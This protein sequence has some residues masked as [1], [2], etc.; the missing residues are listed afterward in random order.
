MRATATLRD[1]DPFFFVQH[2]SRLETGLTFI[3]RSKYVKSS[4]QNNRRR[5]WRL[6]LED[7]EGSVGK[8]VIHNIRTKYPT[9]ETST[10][11]RGGGRAETIGA[12]FL[13]FVKSIPSNIAIPN[14]GDRNSVE[15]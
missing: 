5:H 10:V 2:P 13:P 6:V 8:M 4:V 14:R 7:R 9:A 11:K 1:V 15:W 3:S 12:N